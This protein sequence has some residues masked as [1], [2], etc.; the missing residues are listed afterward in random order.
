MFFDRHER[1]VMTT[2]NRRQVHSV[3][4]IHMPPSGYSPLGRLVA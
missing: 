2:Q 1:Y 4:W 3:C